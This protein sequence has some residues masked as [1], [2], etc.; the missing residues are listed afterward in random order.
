M[1]YRPVS[2]YAVTSNF[3]SHALETQIHRICA[4][5]CLN[6][7]VT[8]LDMRSRDFT[9][10]TS[11]IDNCDIRKVI[12]EFEAI[13]TNLRVKISKSN[14][15]I[16]FEPL[17]TSTLISNGGHQPKESNW[18]ESFYTILREFLKILFVLLILLI[19][20]KRDFLAFLG[21]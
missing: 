19:L 2:T 16:T 21:L 1:D 14:I 4:S 13:A 18:I 5:N 20:S 6:F 10:K 7:T 11:A 17:V 8:N 12:S 3:D 9:L 15:T